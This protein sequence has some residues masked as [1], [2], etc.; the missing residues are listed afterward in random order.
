MFIPTLCTPATPRAPVWAELSQ[1]PPAEVRMLLSKL[2]LIVGYNGETGMIETLGTGVI[3]GNTDTVYVLSAL[4]IL[5]GFADRTF[6]PAPRTAFT[7]LGDEHGVQYSR[8]ARLIDE[9]RVKVL[10]EFRNPGELVELDV[11]NASGG[12]DERHLDIVL[13][14]CLRS[15]APIEMD[16]ITSLAIDTDPIDLNEPMVMA[17][18]V[19]GK[20]VPFDKQSDSMFG[21]RCRALVRAGYVGEIAEDPEGGRPGG[22]LWRANMPS[23]PGMSGG[24]LIRLRYP[25][26]QSVQ[27]V[28]AAVM[29]VLTVVGI[30]SRGRPGGMFAPLHCPEGETWVT[31][32]SRAD[33]LTTRHAD[34]RSFHFGEE[35]AKAGFLLTYDDLRRRL[36]EEPTPAAPRN[37]HET[38]RV[39][40]HTRKPSV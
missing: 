3:V 20:A 29:Q 9:G 17:G 12:T 31:P 5:T 23:E 37:G 11:W 14:Q 26:G 22:T 24:P 35:L 15:D 33:V 34:G 8:M 10:V 40:M 28:G 39:R 36:A 13:L 38:G 7:G 21:G 18:L 4:H 2:A 6:G 30:V 32:V 19:G 1:L 25:R 16:R 27:V